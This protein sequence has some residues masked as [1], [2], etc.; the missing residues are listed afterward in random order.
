M[1]KD[2]E[3]DRERQRERETEKVRNRDRVTRDQV[4]FGAWVGRE[5]ERE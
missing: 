1:G 2:I 5:M 4:F 3:K